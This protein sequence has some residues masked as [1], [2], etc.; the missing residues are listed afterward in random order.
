MPSVR[1][2]QVLPEEARRNVA[3]T[4]LVDPRTGL[5]LRHEDSWV[6]HPPVRLPLAWRRL[7]CACSNAVYR[8]LGWERELRVAEAHKPSWEA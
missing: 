4:L 8:L 7:N 3:T 5:V 1:P 6:H 2:L